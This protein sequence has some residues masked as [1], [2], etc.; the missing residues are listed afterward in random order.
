M[1]RVTQILTLSFELFYRTNERTC[2]SDSYDDFLTIFKQTV[3]ARLEK[4]E[5]SPNDKNFFTTINDL[6]DKKT[7]IEHITG[8]SSVVKELLS[9]VVRHFEVLNTTVTKVT[10]S[11]N[12]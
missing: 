7:D 11:G 12:R 6:L 8:F 5:L 9:D 4:K 1:E 3:R 2:L 10:S